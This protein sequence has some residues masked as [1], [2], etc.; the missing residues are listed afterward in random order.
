MAEVDLDKYLTLDC[1]RDEFTG[2][3][4]DDLAEFL[5]DDEFEPRVATPGPVSACVAGAAPLGCV[6]VARGAWADVRRVVWGD[7][8]LTTRASPPPPRPQDYSRLVIFDGLPN[9]GKFKKPSKLKRFVEKFLAQIAEV[10]NVEVQTQKVGDDEVAMGAAI[11]EFKTAE[12]AHEA[13]MHPQ[14]SGIEFQGRTFQLNLFRDI[15]KCVHAF[16]AATDG[17]HAPCA[18]AATA[19]TQAHAS[20][21]VPLAHHQVPDPARGGQGA[22]SEAVRE[23]RRPVQ[24]DVR[25]GLP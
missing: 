24:L 21:A 5:S 17:P 12:M 20:R 6:G 13:V 22:G 3:E 19:E 7:G 18:A 2:E 9:S 25:H 15:E 16:A 10:T 14:T 4:L 8:A 23:Q 1:V 11:V